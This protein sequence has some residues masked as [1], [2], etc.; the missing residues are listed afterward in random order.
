VTDGLVEQDD[1]IALSR[2]VKELPWRIDHGQATC[3]VGRTTAGDLSVATGKPLQAR[4]DDR[5]HAPGSTSSQNFNSTLM[6]NTERHG[7]R[8]I[9]SLLLLYEHRMG[10]VN[11]ARLERV[12]QRSVGPGPVVLPRLYSSAAI[13]LIEH[14][15]IDDWNDLFYRGAQ[16]SH[17]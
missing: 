4:R 3:F 12:L 11:G 8:G 6:M 1:H 2:L 9:S 13:R 14:D 16:F 5:S 7:A 17:E 10:L 15:L